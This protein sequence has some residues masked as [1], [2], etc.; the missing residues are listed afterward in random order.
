MSSCGGREENR[1]PSC[2]I[3]SVPYNTVQP[4]V[5]QEVAYAMDI[6]E[7]QVAV[8]KYRFTVE[9]Y[10][11]IG[12]AGI[13]SEDDRVELIDGEVVKMTPI[14]WR[15]AW[16]VNTLNMLL[17]RPAQSRYVVSVQNPLIISE[18]GEPQPD[19]ALLRNLPAGRLPA[20]GDVLLVVEVSDTTLTY[21][22]NVKLSRY[23]EAGIAE[24][25][26]VDLNS[27]TFEVHSGPG[28]GV[29]RRTTRFGRGDRVESA[30]VPDL[31]FDADEALPPTE[32]EG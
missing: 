1:T 22:K 4:P 27:E 6:V 14:G 15:H 17:A 3:L 2:L 9:E 32:P 16:C 7:Q 5:V 28:P 13:F 18:H 20:P 23:A 30:T 26:L 12:E 24:A 29:Y 8:R 11:K 25:W 31:A 10:H 21:D 19:L